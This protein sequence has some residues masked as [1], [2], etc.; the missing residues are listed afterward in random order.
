MAS[1]L[2]RSKALLKSDGW[3]CWK[4]EHYNPWS[5]RKTD[6][7]NMLDLIAIR[8]D[9]PGVL[10]LQVCGEDIAIHIHKLLSGYCVSSGK[11]KGTLIPP[12][13]YLPIWLKAGNPFFIWGWRLREHK[14]TKDT[15]QLREVEFILQDGIVV[16]REVA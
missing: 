11:Y 3:L 2:E 13:P 9:R 14:G 6:V 4:T 10:G 1:P 5:M 16:N 12:N 8:P 7:F 15:Y